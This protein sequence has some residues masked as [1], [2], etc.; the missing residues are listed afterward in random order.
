MQNLLC[1]SSPTNYSD[2]SSVVTTPLYVIQNHALLRPNLH[3][4]SSSD[5][6]FTPIRLLHEQLPVLCPRCPS[7][8]CLHTV[9]V[10]VV[11]PPGSAVHLGL[12]PRQ[13][14]WVLK[15]QTSGIWHGRDWCSSSGEGFHCIGTDADLTHK[16]SCTKVQECWVWS[17][18]QERANVQ[19]SQPQQVSLHLCW[20]VGEGDNIYQFFCPWRDA[21][22]PDAL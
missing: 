16:D 18:A 2:S 22:L 9:C 14:S 12:H 19:V 7:D 15:L 8:H 6:T 5:T 13:A 17:K 11:W 20:V 10:W 21:S 1:H 3:S 4:S